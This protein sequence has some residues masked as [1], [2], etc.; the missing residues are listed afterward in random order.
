MD[1]RL[2]MRSPNQLIVLAFALAASAFSSFAQTT[3]SFRVSTNVPGAAFWVDGRKFTDSASF[4]WEPGSQ[5]ILE[6]RL[7]AQ[8]DVTRTTRWSFTGWADDR[9]LIAMPS[10]PVQVVTANASTQSF[11]ASFTKQHRVD[12]YVSGD[13]NELKNLCHSEDLDVIAPVIPSTTPQEQYASWAGF[14]MDQTCGCI[15]A[16]TYRWVQEGDSL[17]LNA[18]PYP[19]N[20][21][22][23]FRSMSNPGGANIS[24]MVVTGPMVLRAVFEPGRR[25]IFRTERIPTYQTNQQF[26]YLGLNVVV[27]RVLIPTRDESNQCSDA[28]AG[29]TNGAPLPP[30]G[31][32][33]LIPGSTIK[34]CVALGLCNGERDL[35]AG[36][37]VVIGVPEVQ[38]DRHKDYWVFDYWDPGNGTKLGQNAVIVPLPENKPSIYTARFTKGV[39]ARFS[40]DPA[41]VKLKVDGSDHWRTYSFVWGVGHKHRVEAPLQQ[42]DS[43]GRIWE[44]TG[45][46]NGGEAVQEIEITDDM[47]GKGLSLHAN[48]RVLGRVRVDTVPSGVE[49][50]TG[51][52]NCKTPCVLNRAQGAQT[53]LVAPSEVN[54]SP[55]TKLVFIGWDDGVSSSG[56]VVEFSA[57]SSNLVARYRRLE[58]LTLISDPPDAAVFN[59]E[60]VSEPGSWFETGTKVLLTAEAQ[61]G[62]KFKYYEGA[63]SGSMNTG[64]LTMNAPATVVARMEK[65]RQ[66]A[67]H[68]VRN[69]AGE[70]PIKAVAPGSRIAI[71]GYNLSAESEIGPEQPLAQVLQGV[72]I[73]LG[74][75]ILPLISVSPNFIEAFLP[76][77]LEPGPYSLT[78]RSPGEQPVSTKFDVVR[79]APGLF[80]NVVNDINYALA[81]HGNG[82]LVDPAV[83]VQPGD[84]VE[85]LATGF[86]P[87]NPQPL[88]GFATPMSPPSPIRDAI[89]LLVDGQSQPVLFAG[90]APGRTGFQLVRF[91]V[92]PAWGTGRN[93]EVR[94]RVNG[95]ESNAVLLPVR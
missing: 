26:P 18:I 38:Q 35:L 23:G 52:E 84:R 61:P 53:E 44:F 73:T 24:S 45:W 20:V 83:G 31:N 86:G 74:N 75:R 28:V 50:W 51:D 21:F 9:G 8:Y 43:T 60:P 30:Y 80:R 57:A 63:L 95:Q 55:D 47:A 72:T 92:D 76:S 40:T 69:A 64:W 34:P 4:S 11:V 6:V 14:V 2:S 78:V 91:L 49:V 54:L 77:D 41:P 27:D 25:H 89:E 67:E 94:V 46:S 36:Q 85:I 33:F 10:N 19:G 7:V 13:N 66:L 3:V 16:S 5:H 22:T 56:R 93:L 81:L 32:P 39:I 37:R 48:Y 70:T 88:D 17:V 71:H 59:T 15:P 58:K 65:V 12:I 90:A 79:N 68:S 82:E 29:E 1:V 87:M 62:Y 42:T